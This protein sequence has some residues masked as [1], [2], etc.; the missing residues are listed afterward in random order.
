MTLYA[1]PQ[2]LCV[3][4]ER[5]FCAAPATSAARGRGR[6]PV[7][8]AGRAAQLF[9][10]GI[11]MPRVS[12]A[13]APGGGEARRPPCRAGELGPMAAAGPRR[14]LVGP[15]SGHAAGAQARSDS[16]NCVR[17]LW[18]PGAAAAGADS[19]AWRTTGGHPR[20]RWL[21]RLRQAWPQVAARRGAISCRAIL[22]PCDERLHRSSSWPTRLEGTKYDFYSSSWE[23]LVSFY[24]PLG[25]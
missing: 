12:G 2:I 4:A 13:V 16:H 9:A 11:S 24:L 6:R 10:P 8:L 5:T 25:N 20:G 3:S 1:S 7:G 18:R 23:H 22:V 21:L 15:R 19:G 17:V 14:A